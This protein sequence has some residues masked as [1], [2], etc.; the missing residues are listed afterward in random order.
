MCSS[1]SYDKFTEIKGNSCLPLPTLC[2][3]ECVVHVH[4]HVHVSRIHMYVRMYMM[5]VYICDNYMCRCECVVH[6]HVYGYI[7]LCGTCNHKPLPF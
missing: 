6:V 4:V 5:C 2:V 1:C 7:C 3:G